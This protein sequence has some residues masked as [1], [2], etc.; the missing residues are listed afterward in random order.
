M[1]VPDNVPLATSARLST[2][3]AAAPPQV[4]HPNVDAGGKIC[5]DILSEKWSAAYSVHTLLLSLQSLL[6]EPNNASPLN[7]AAA[8]LWDDAV[9]GG[10]CRAAVLGACR[11]AV[12]HAW[13]RRRR[14]RSLAPVALLALLS[15]SP[16]PLSSRVTP[17]A[18]HR[19]SSARPSCGSTA[20]PRGRS[21]RA[22]GAP[23]ARH[24]G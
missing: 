6:G 18:E 1:L 20:R 9:R 13:R 21:L 3:I 11:S 2:V 19:P 4:F 12:Q 16:L 8:T 22:G 15:L 14:G 10:G 23:L 5:L 7:Q 24:D 17:S